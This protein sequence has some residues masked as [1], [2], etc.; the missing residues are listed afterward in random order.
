MRCIFIL[1]C[2]IFA[3]TSCK[4]LTR[5]IEITLPPA[6][7]QM[8]VECYLRPGLPFLLSL[9]ETNDY[10]NS[11]LAEIKSLE[12]AVV[13]VTHSGQTD[14]LAELTIPYRGRNLTVYANFKMVP[15]DTVNTFRLTIKA[16][17][18]RMVWAET[19]ILPPVVIDSL[20]QVI[21]PVDAKRAAVAV[22]KDKA[23][24]RDFYR[25]ITYKN[26]KDSLPERT[27]RFNDQLTN[28]QDIISA[29]GYRFAPKDTLY[30]QLYHIEQA[31]YDFLQSGSA[32]S[33]ANGNPFAQP[34]L[35]RSNIKGG[36]GIFTGMS[37]TEKVIIVR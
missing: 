37:M 31:Y 32:A 33:S 25:M 34:A 22:I 29:T 1:I 19:R 10:F 35:L 5:D 14:T 4:N 3:L 7:P 18:G 27:T 9:N 16:A 36:V 21:S 11:N 26:S 2:F 17:D 6:T 20:R 23:E 28:G 30:W 8:Q 12:H 24:T 15:N 13:T